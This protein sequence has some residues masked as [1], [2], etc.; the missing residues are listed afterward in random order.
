L[1]RPRRSFLS[2]LPPSCQLLDTLP[3]HQPT[4]NMIILH[5]QHY[6]HQA[7]S[8]CARYLRT[9]GCSSVENK[10][11]DNSY[12]HHGWLQTSPTRQCSSYNPQ[13]VLSGKS[14]RCCAVE[15]GHCVLASRS[16]SNGAA[17]TGV[18]P[19]ALEATPRSTQDRQIL[20]G[21]LQL[22]GTCSMMIFCT[23]TASVQE[24]RRSI[25]G[26]TIQ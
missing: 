21:D 24:T 13:G 5:P 10:R 25:L 19:R 2:S 15:D 26:H 6:S 12:L 20:P 16:E 8:V 11:L 23:R 7:F 22:G 9:A 17:R 4:S 18:D 3:S 14:S 1:T